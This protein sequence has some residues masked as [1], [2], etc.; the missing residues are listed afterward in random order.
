MFPDLQKKSKALLEKI[1]DQHRPAAMC[2]AAL[3]G[4]ITVFSGANALFGNDDAEPQNAQIAI[5]ENPP[6]YGNPLLGIKRSFL[7]VSDAETCEA[8]A[9][10]MRAYGKNINDPQ[11]EGLTIYANCVQ[12]GPDQYSLILQNGP[13]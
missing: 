4:L 10:A 3:L 12:T 11:F 13:E 5:S 6:I 7:S 2:G 1:P 8:A 9:E